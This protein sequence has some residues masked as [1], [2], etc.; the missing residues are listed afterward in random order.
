MITLVLATECIGWFILS[1]SAAIYPL[2]PSIPF[3]VTLCSLYVYPTTAL[4]RKLSVVGY[5][6]TL[7]Y[8]HIGNY[9]QNCIKE[10]RVIL[11]PQKQNT[12]TLVYNKK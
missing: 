9:I 6:P 1:R 3:V 2:H 10:K 7:A 4:Y 5:R 11:K 8:K 12:V